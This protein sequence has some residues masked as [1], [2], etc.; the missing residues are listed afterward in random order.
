MHAHK[1]EINTIYTQ[2]L[3]RIEINIGIRHKLYRTLY[4]RCTIT[5]SKTAWDLKNSVNVCV[6]N[7][8][9]KIL[10][11]TN[12]NTLYNKYQLKK[13]NFGNFPLK[14]YNFKNFV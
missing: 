6:Y 10:T 9:H 13:D 2:R 4:V 12:T 3:Q 8:Q 14:E 1:T 5:K 7:E 11:Y